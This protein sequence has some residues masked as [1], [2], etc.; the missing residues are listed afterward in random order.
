M[1]GDQYTNIILC[2]NKLCV[3]KRRIIWKLDNYSIRTK[4]VGERW[5]SSPFEFLDF[6]YSDTQWELRF[7]PVGGTPLSISSW[8]ALV[9]WTLTEL[10]KPCCNMSWLAICMLQS[11][12]CVIVM[13]LELFFF[14]K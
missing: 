7:Y 8:R 6:Y 11:T 5:T 9:P 2:E 14:K 3:I 13:L 10:T 12:F 1:G 4:V